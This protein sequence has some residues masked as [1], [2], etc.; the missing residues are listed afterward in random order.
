MLKTL[1][2]EQ[3]VLLTLFVFLFVLLTGT[4]SM[5]EQTM[6]KIDW[7]DGTNVVID[8]D[9]N[10]ADGW[11]RV[12][13]DDTINGT[14]VTKMYRNSWKD[15]EGR[16]HSWVVTDAKKGITDPGSEGEPDPGRLG[17][18][19][20]YKSNPKP[21][22]I[23]TEFDEDPGLEGYAETPP[24]S[25]KWVG[26]KSITPPNAD[27]SG[28]EAAEYFS[29]NGSDNYGADTPTILFPSI[30][31]PNLPPSMPSGAVAPG[32]VPTITV[33]HSMP[34]DGEAR[35]NTEVFGARWNIIYKRDSN[36]DKIEY[37]EGFTVKPSP[38]TVPSSRDCRTDFNNEP[39]GYGISNLRLL[40]SKT[41]NADQTDLNNETIDITVKKNYYI[42]TTDR[43][44]NSNIGGGTTSAPMSSSNPVA[45]LD[46]NGDQVVGANSAIP[47]FVVDT[48]NPDIHSD[49]SL[50]AYNETS[51]ILRCGATIGA[52]RFFVYDNNLNLIRYA[53]A[54][55]E[56]RIRSGIAE[57]GFKTPIDPSPSGLPVVDPVKK[58]IDEA[59]EAAKLADLKLVLA[60]GSVRE[61]T[62]A[63]GGPD[64][65]ERAT[66]TGSAL[67]DG[68]VAS[69]TPYDSWKV[70]LTWNRDSAEKWPQT[71]KGSIYP[72]FMVRNLGPDPTVGKVLPRLQ[73]VDDLRPSVFVMVVEANKDRYYPATGKYYSEQSMSPTKVRIDPSIP[74]SG[75]GY[76][77][78]KQL[79]EEVNPDF[80]DN[81]PVWYT[82]VK[83]F[84]KT[85][86]SFYVVV[87]ENITQVNNMM[88]DQNQPPF[89]SDYKYHIKV[90]GLKF[91]WS[92][93]SA[94]EVI[95]SE[96]ERIP[97]TNLV[98]FRI[99]GSRQWRNPTNEDT[100]DYLTLQVEDASDVVEPR[101]LDPETNQPNRRTLRV[102]FIAQDTKMRTNTMSGSR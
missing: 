60:D 87:N 27:A 68:W 56:T 12:V 49:Y 80:S 33:A 38:F 47:V 51:G 41:Y 31:S 26:T 96:P 34:T 85:R 37:H 92:D 23:T 8:S 22:T 101:F 16:L 2:L 52:L 99:Q 82:T 3:A 77:D 35:D 20:V 30:S 59:E 64:A 5:A 40:F 42:S 95:T 53:N 65:I 28:T 98:K 44:Y 17:P 46:T 61:F 88:T 58:C 18:Q 1:N 83:V 43:F 70:R 15:S 94:E 67:V 76:T 21:I 75:P 29:L 93:Q 74:D 11:N 19:H 91:Q 54:D 86:Y 78:P 90:K 10:P 50:A 7:G 66:N 89:D 100:A 102:F 72:K 55:Q 63:L 69:Q 62:R 48:M 97:G 25:G 79:L 24:G 73:L 71:F 45:V 9:P 13:V 57:M 6:M 81:N 36:V 32:Q 39:F 4:E 84:E 14:R